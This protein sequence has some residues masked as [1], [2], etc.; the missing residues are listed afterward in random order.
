MQPRV[1]VLW[2][3][4]WPAVAAL[5][6]AGLSV[7]RPAVILTAGRIQVATAA[8]RACGIRAGMKRRD[9][10]SRCPEVTI[11]GS[12]PDRDARMFEPVAAAVE[13]VAPGIEVLRPGLIACGARG[14]ARYFGSEDAAAERIVDA[15]EALDV[16]CRIGI[17]GGLSTAVLAARQSAIVPAGSPDA[18]FCA[19]LP[20]AELA[21]DP[22]IAPP[23]WDELIDLLQ[24]L[25]ITTAGAFAALPI[26]KVATRFGADG[27]ALH[28]LAS[29]HAERDLSR[30]RI[31]VDIA[32]EEDYDPPLERVDTAAFAGR[33][34][35]VRFHTR[36]AAAG[37]A[38]TRLDITAVREHGDTLRRTWRC[39]RPL[40]MA[41]TADRLRWQLDGWLTRPTRGATPSGALIRIRLDAVD[42]VDSGRIQYGLWG[43]DGYGDYRAGTAFARVQGLLGTAAVLATLRSGGR[44]PTDRVSLA[45][46]GEADSPKRDPDGPWP[47]ALP[48]PA[49]ARAI[50]A[51]EPHAPES[52]PAPRRAPGEAPAPDTEQVD[53]CDPSGYR[54]EVTDRGMLTGPPASVAGRSVL[55][56][57]GPWLLDERWW[58]ATP[59]AGT[60]SG[61]TTP[62]V[63]P[64]V[65]PGGARAAVPAAAPSVASSRRWARMQVV[66]DPGPPV[67]LELGARG[68]LVEAIYD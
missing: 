67:L 36:L 13:E 20:I 56:W 25:G 31:E 18:E 38:C 53:V 39:V 52:L 54:V 29:G 66:T 11:L 44:G 64:G 8:A 30:R 40:D 58:S 34:L 46:W 61:R 60:G 10:V 41:G 63:V 47:G 35:A 4:D 42:V 15:V 45:A 3:P 16:E 48:T 21:R 22:A 17:A 7:D 68:W 26:Q 32:V 6:Q 50:H 1:L 62:D 2:C 65:V 57:A 55:S 28:R 24:R 51:L 12:D 59:D 9:A 49:P 19:P 37:L 5:R 33:A 27:V 14:P 23:Q 43:A